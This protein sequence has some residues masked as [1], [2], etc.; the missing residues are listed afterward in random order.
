M[1]P[2]KPKQDDNGIVRTY[3]LLNVGTFERDHGQEHSVLDKRAVFHQLGASEC[4]DG[5]EDHRGRTGEVA[6]C[7]AIQ[8]NVHLWTMDTIKEGCAMESR[9]S[10][11][12]LFDNRD[13]AYLLL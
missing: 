12:T 11:T 8:T 6:L 2:N 5:L 7:D 13:G 9:T 1:S 4:G 3:L 10:I